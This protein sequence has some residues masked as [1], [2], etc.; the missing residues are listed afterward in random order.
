MRLEIDRGRRRHGIFVIRLAFDDVRFGY[1]GSGLF[2]SRSTP[3]LDGS[4]WR[5]IKPVRVVA[6]GVGVRRMTSS[7]Q[8]V[9][10]STQR[11]HVPQQAAQGAR[12]RLVLVGRC[13]LIHSLDH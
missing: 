8:R 6:L 13:R 1:P 10:A 4:S 7:D 12:D 3:V 11:P 2:G 5:A 9:I